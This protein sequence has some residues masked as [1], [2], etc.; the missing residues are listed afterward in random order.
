MISPSI[1]GYESAFDQTVALGYPVADVV[2]LAGLMWLLNT[3][4]LRTRSFR[5]LTAALV[6]LLIADVIFI[7]TEGQP[8]LDLPWATCPS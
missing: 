5:L 3:S 8:I 1:G 4:S 2:L 6:L 7:M